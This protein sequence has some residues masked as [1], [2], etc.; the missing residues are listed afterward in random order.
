MYIR[1]RYVQIIAIVPDSVLVPSAIRKSG[2]CTFSKIMLFNPKFAIGIIAR[3]YSI[4]RNIWNP[5]N[6]LILSIVFLTAVFHEK[7]LLFI[8]PYIISVS[9]ENSKY[10]KN[11]NIN[12]YTINNIILIGFES[13][14]KKVFWF[15]FICLIENSISLNTPPK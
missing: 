2:M 4:N 15:M 7:W 3:I 14:S 8:L 12:I 13:I 1:V 6:F 9:S 5:N 10:T 11:A